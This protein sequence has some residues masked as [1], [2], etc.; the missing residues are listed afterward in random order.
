MSKFEVVPYLGAKPPTNPVGAKRDSIKELRSANKKLA[1]DTRARDKRIKE[2]ESR[3]DA[4]L[5][6]RP[7]NPTCESFSHAKKDWGHELGTCP[8]V[9][10]WHTA[11]DLA[12]GALASGRK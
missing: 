12:V 3:L 4:V 7:C 6:N 8:C 1:A 11:V 10:R 2:L 9:E 5:R